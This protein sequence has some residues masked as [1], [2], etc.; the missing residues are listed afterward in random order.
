MPTVLFIA[1]IL[2]AGTCDVIAKQVIKIFMNDTATPAL[3]PA[4][5]L[6]P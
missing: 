1:A 6:H 5:P 4:L 2:I 3:L